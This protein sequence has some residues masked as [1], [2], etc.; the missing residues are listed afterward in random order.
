[1]IFP[2]DY[3]LVGV[4][5]EF[6]PS[7][8]IY[9]A[10]EYLISLGSRPEETAIYRTSSSGQG[11]MRR[12]KAVEVISNGPEIVWYPEVVDTRNRPVLIDLASRICVGGV[13]TVIFKG[14]DEHITFVHEPDPSAIL[15]IEVLDV[16]PPE[17]PWLVLV[18]DRLEK[19]GILGE[20]TVRFK[21]KLLDLRSFGGPD[22]Y[23]PCR[24]SGLGRS[25]DSDR[26]E[27][28][29]PKIVG[30]EVSREIFLATA[31]PRDYEFVNICPVSGGLIVPCGPFITRCCRSER[32]G[33]VR[34]GGHPG[35]VVHWGDGYFRV[36]QAIRMLV[37]EIRTGC[38]EETQMEKI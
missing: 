11:F 3:K 29:H 4:T 25:L 2:D 12:G 16:M 27:S 32:R 36:A 21:E 22:V 6:R 19:S 31:S 37:E 18:I 5:G 7:D 8:P 15:E 38:E 9:F 1:M 13:K 35:V 14:P 30:C 28:D 33:L 20:L 17:P 23:F 26:V 24:A 10:T 34:I